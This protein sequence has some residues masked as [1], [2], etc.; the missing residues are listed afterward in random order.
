M[1]LSLTDLNA[2]QHES[3]STEA[4]SELQSPKT[5]HFPSGYTGEEVRKMKCFNQSSHS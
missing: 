4:T 1:C 5:E 3:D 2:D